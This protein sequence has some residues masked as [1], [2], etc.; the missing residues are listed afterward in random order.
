MPER[1]RRRPPVQVGEK[2]EMRLVLVRD[3]GKRLARQWRAGVAIDRPADAVGPERAE[4]AWRCDV[5]VSSFIC[6]WLVAAQ[7]KARFGN[8]S[9]GTEETLVANGEPS[10]QAQST[11]RS[12]A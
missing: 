12:S 9:V 11:G 2:P 10:R 3:I 8:V 6:P 1:A 4:D 7:A 5:F